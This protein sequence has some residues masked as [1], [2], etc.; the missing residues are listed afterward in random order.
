M[1]IIDEKREKKIV[2]ATGAFQVR[3][4]CDNS[5]RAQFNSRIGAHSVSTSIPF[6][7]PPPL[8]ARFLLFQKET[9]TSKETPSTRF[10]ATIVADRSRGIVALISFFFLFS[11]F[12][13]RP[14][15]AHEPILL[16]RNRSPCV[17]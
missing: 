7:S 11:Y 16:Q 17:A 6:L 14:R 13:L 1:N 3:G 12:P 15:S 10:K 4:G 2:P 5:P 8:S 9:S